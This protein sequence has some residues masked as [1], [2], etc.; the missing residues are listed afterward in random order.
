MRKIQIV[1]KAKAGEMKKIFNEYLLEIS[2]FDKNIKFD[3]QGAPIYNWFDCY[4]QEGSRFPFYLIVDDKIAGLALVREEGNQFY[5]IGEFYVL[6]EFRKKE[7]ALWF[8][9]AIVDMFDG[10]FEFS[11]DRAN[12]RA[13]NFWDKFSKQFSGNFAINSGSRRSWTIKKEKQ[14]DTAPSPEQTLEDYR[15]L[16]IANNVLNK[17]FIGFYTREFYCFD[18]FSAFGFVYKDKYWQ[19]IEHAYQ[20]LKFENTAP[21]IVEEIRQSTSPGQAKILAYKYAD[22]FDAT[23]DA[24]KVAVMEEILRAKLQQHPHVQK[25]LIETANFTL[26]E[27]S[28]V[29][30][31]WGIG[32]DGKGQNM[33]GKLWMKL[34]DELKK[35]MKKSKRNKTK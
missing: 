15:D 1:S 27:D 19:T 25:K 13:V 6:P 20:A 18:N 5:E 29:D 12:E 3:E 35:E 14:V 32:A 31:F 28:P 10:D 16:F 9:S 30:S 21:E 33:M 7:N 2:Q 8:A 11:T 24:R 23:W 17:N 22:K 26:C 34:R 4:W